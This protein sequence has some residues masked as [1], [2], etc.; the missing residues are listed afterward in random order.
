MRSKKLLY[1]VTE[2]WYFV[3]HRLALAIAARKAG[4]D[5][6]V[7]TRVRGHGRMIEEA[8]LRL[9]PLELR[10]RGMNPLVELPLLWRLARIYRRE[11]PDIAHHV[12]M[13]P[14]LYGSLAALV[15]RT[16][17]V[18]NAL[19][20]LGW[21]FTSRS[22]RARALGGVVRTLFSILLK[23]G[24]V[25]VQNP[26]DARWLT[27]TGVPANHVHLIR[28]SGVDAKI[29]APRAEPAGEPVVMLA[30]R[31]LWDKGVAEFVEAARL[32]RASGPSARFV[33]VG[34]ADVENPA[35]IP[36][37]RLVQWRDEGMVEWWGWRED[38]PATLAQ[39][40]IVC[41]PSYRE[42]LPRVLI[43]AAAC[44]RPIVTTDVPGCREIVR[45]GENGLRVPPRNAGALAAAIQRL[46][47]DAALRRRMG[48]RGRALVEAEFSIE[49]VMAE[50]LALY[51][52]LV[53]PP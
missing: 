40:S 16:P 8:G 37:S 4:F 27:E 51:R 44:A 1:F 7:V 41:L 12:A 24:E 33:L 45:E 26:D 5:V 34:E 13:K 50:T 36:V 31:M 32:L 52:R 47:N 18:V 29:F 10:R 38:M 2:D 3:S 22:L 30:S 11:R 46:L 28:G 23:R 39:A 19:A 25:V 53:G 49:K 35:S 43:E 48:E 15:A 21:L 9:L 17:H 42:G 20:G 6:I 14:V